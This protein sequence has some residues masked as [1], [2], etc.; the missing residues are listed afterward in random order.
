MARKRKAPESGS[1][2]APSGSPAAEKLEPCWTPCD[3]CEEMWCVKHKAHAFECPCPSIEA[4][5]EQ[6]VWPYLG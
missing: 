2:S 1:N 6:D 4:F 5:A 3:F